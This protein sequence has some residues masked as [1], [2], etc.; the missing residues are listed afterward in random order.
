VQAGYNWQAGNFV[1][2]VEGDVD[3]MHLKGTAT[4]GPVLYACCAPAVFVLTSQASADW[5]ATIRG[6]LGFASNNWLFFAT[7]GAAFTQL[8]GNFTFTDNRSTTGNCG[9]A[10]TDAHEAVSLSHT[11]TGWTVGGGIEY[12]VGGGWSVKA[13]YL[14]LQFDR[15]SG[16]GLL[17][18][19]VN[20][21]NNNPFTHSIDLKANI[22]RLGVNYRF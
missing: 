5:V 4:S 15:I 8:K 20:G 21:S 12:G 6:R 2:G 9:G 18:P 1:F 3:W 19:V 16:A 22:A 13:E 7:G 17:N 11:K 14:Y 10:G